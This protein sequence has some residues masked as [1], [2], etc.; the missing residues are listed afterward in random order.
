MIY[1]SEYQQ[2]DITN[3]IH[4]NALN[5]SKSVTME[6]LP[7]FHYRGNSIDSKNFKNNAQKIFCSPITP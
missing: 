4:G 6:D 3:N 2:C 5:Q 1:F 7:E